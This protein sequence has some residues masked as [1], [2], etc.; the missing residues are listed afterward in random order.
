MVL[1]VADTG[2]RPRLVL[3]PDT[4]IFRP[5]D[6]DKVRLAWGVT[7]PLVANDPKGRRCSFT[8]EVRRDGGPEGV[9]RWTPSVDLVDIDDFGVWRVRVEAMNS[10]GLWDTGSFLVTVREDAIVSG[11]NSYRVG[12]FGTQVWMLENLRTL[13]ATAGGSWCY[14]DQDSACATY[15]RMYDW[16]TAT[17]GQARNL[18]PGSDSDF[19]TRIRGICPEGWHLPSFDEFMVLKSWLKRAGSIPGTTA[20]RLLPDERVGRALESDTLW[21]PFWPDTT[22]RGA[23]GFDLRP[24]GY[25]N[26]ANQAFEFIGAHTG[27]WT[28]SHFRTDLARAVGVIENKFYNPEV[29]E[30]FETQSAAG[31]LLY[32][33]M[34]L[35]SGFYVRCLED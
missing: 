12:Q 34:S 5:S 14:G 22:W 31:Q 7:R 2:T 21:N 10:V 9:V 25:R 17:A 15:G 8:Y 27:L 20:T 11:G 3:P 18:Q 19:T 16:T 6:Y 26:P 23:S 28:S 13:P 32:W 4:V 35:V 24:G 1:V 33:D 29:D 30:H